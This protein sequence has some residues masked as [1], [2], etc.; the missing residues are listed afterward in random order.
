[1]SPPNIWRIATIVLLVVVIILGIALALTSRQV[2]VQTITITQTKFIKK[3][4]YIERKFNP[5]SGV[6]IS[7]KITDKSEETNKDT[8]KDKATEKPATKNFIVG[9]GYAPLGGRFSARLGIVFLDTFI[10]DVSNPVALELSPSI[11]ASII[12]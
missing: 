10:V 1:M 7:E 5:A 9:I 12:F 11:T 4:V 6:M 2:K 8:I 3:N